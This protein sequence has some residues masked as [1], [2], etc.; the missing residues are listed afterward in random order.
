MSLPTNFFIGRGGGSGSTPYPI[1][2]LPN[3]SSTQHSGSGTFTN[4]TDTN[5]TFNG[6]YGGVNSFS[7]TGDASSLSSEVTQSGT[8][9]RKYLKLV[10]NQ[11]QAD[12]LGV[13]TVSLSGCR[14][15][16]HY[17]GQTSF[18]V[19]G[20]DGLTIT[21]EIDFPALYS[22]YQINYSLNMIVFLGTRGIDITN[23]SANGSSGTAAS[24]G[25]ASAIAVYT[26]GTNFDPV[27]VSAGGGGAYAQNTAPSHRAGLDA[28]MPSNPYDTTFQGHVQYDPGS[29]IGLTDPTLLTT[30]RPWVDDKPNSTGSGNGASWNEIGLGYVGGGSYAGNVP[31]IKE[32]IQAWLVNTY[33]PQNI[34][35]PRGQTFDNSTTFSTYG[36][37]NGGSYGG[38]GGAG[39]YGGFRG[40]FQ[41]SG[42]SDFG[43]ARGGQGYVN[44][45]Y[46]TFVSSTTAPTILGKME[47]VA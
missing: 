24:G 28:F 17:N 16:N 34:D 47:I 29:G 10:L 41:S 46:A 43:R 21:S 42:A 5:Y 15:G 44:P 1:S 14:G 30:H 23:S 12:T 33:T 3:V 37:G 39:Y 8:S 32:Y 40:H 6:Y 22:A 35:N 36:G 18:N 26:G 9:S 20:G 25:G 7:V 38:G 45:S 13:Q 31:S 19:L 11:T 4:Q 2:I 27:V